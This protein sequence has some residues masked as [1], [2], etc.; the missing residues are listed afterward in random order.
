MAKIQQQIELGSFETTL[1]NLAVTNNATQLLNSTCNEVTEIRAVVVPPSSGSTSSSD[2]Y[3]T[4]V[5]VGIV[6]GV[7]FGFLILSVVLYLGL[8]NRRLL[9]MKRE[10]QVPH[11][12]IPGPGKVTHYYQDVLK[13]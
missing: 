5:V 6:L 10:N 2:G 9:E 13:L 12:T 1:R 3:S 11:H 8:K 4:G 7:V